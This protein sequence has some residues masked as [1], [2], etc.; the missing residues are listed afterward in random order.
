MRGVLVCLVLT[1]GLL[2]P[3]AFAMD[4]TAQDAFFARLSALCGKA[5]AGR[6]VTTDPADKDMMG[7][8]MVMHVR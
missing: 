6:L 8:I 7:Q 1:A 4:P 2:M 3:S 5:F